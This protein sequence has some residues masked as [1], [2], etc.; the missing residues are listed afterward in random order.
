MS[1]FD[2]NP[3]PRE[4]VGDSQDLADAS[5]SPSAD[6]LSPLA[7][8]PISC[9]AIHPEAAHPLASHLP[10]DLR[11]TWSWPHLLLFVVYAVVSQFA[12]GIAVLAYYSTNGH[13]SQRQIRRLF[14][15]DPRLIVLGCSGVVAATLMLGRI[16][17]TRRRSCERLAGD[18]YAAA[19]SG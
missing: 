14:E 8:D 4:E 1:L 7:N 9:V 15:S 5:E 12:I 2:D 6:A 13:L 11:I 3:G 17:T 10:E 19:P 18:D 16:E